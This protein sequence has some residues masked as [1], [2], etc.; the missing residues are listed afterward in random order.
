MNKVIIST[1]VLVLLAST[2]YPQKMR[3]KRLRNQSKLEQL[4]KVKLIEA[5]DL[6]RRDCNSIF[7]TTK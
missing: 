6:K 1:I 3:Q 7:C 2:V 5:L 4:E